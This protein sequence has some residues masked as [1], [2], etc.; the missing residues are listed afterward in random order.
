MRRGRGLR[1]QTRRRARPTRPQGRRGQGAGSQRAGRT[2][3]RPGPPRGRNARGAP[4]FNVGKPAPGRSQPPAP[5]C[6]RCRSSLFHRRPRRG[7]QQ[8]RERASLGVRT[9]SGLPQAIEIQGDAMEPRQWEPRRSAISKGL[10]KFSKDF[11]RFQKISRNFQNFPPASRPGRCGGMAG[12]GRGA[13]RGLP[14]AGNPLICRDRTS[15]EPPNLSTTKGFVG[16]SGRRR[17]R[18]DRHSRRDIEASP[19]L[20]LRTPA[21]P[22][23]PGDPLLG[24][25]ASVLGSGIDR[26]LRRS[27]RAAPS[28]RKHP[29]GRRE[30]TTRRA[31]R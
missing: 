12:R 2:A 22:A 15:N 16:R 10:Q 20:Q 1:R 18:R 29:A 7:L 26:C 4:S 5:A 30:W 8:S 31:R 3:A 21:R 24:R 13:A 11:K 14:L 25:S 17:F 9:A 27:A 6:S 19:A 28:G 23:A